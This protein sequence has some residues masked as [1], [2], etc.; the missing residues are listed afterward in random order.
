MNKKQLIR[1]VYFYMASL[2][3]LG[4]V[5]GSCIFLLNLGLKA[6][7]LTDADPVAYRLGPPPS[8][9]FESKV[10][11]TGEPG[12]LTCE[13]TCTLTDSE[14]ASITAW[15]GDYTDWQ[16]QQDNP[17]TDRLR[18]LINGLSFLLISLPIFIIH[19]RFV[20]KDGKQDT[21]REHAVVRPTY[22]YFI[23]LASL[24]MVVIAGGILLNVALKTWIFPSVGE[25]DN[26]D[27]RT[28]SLAYPYSEKQPIQSIITCQETCSIDSETVVLAEQ[29]LV[30]YDAWDQASGAGY[31]N[32][33]RQAAGAIPFILVGIPLFWYHWDTV[34][35]EGRDKKQKKEATS[36]EK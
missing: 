6:W 9:F 22:Y 18:D 15:V 7:V 35:R 11:P 10:S 8:L 13:D 1:S 16:E 31:N 24:V 26:N 20:W 28:E 25:A 17:N 33:N 14:Q 34:R 27:S 2:I 21:D 23:A 32:T 4:I 12:A 19:F 29:W 3:T 5:V 36:E 30:D